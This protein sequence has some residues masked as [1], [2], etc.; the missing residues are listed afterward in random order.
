MT[1]VRVRVGMPEKQTDLPFGMCS[2]L[3]VNNYS[4]FEVNIFGKAVIRKD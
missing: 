1:P 3:I 2:F 4:K